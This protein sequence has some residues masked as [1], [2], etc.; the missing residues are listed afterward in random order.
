ML[1]AFIL[2]EQNMKKNN[3]TSN[4]ISK[5]ATGILVSTALLSISS[6]SASTSEY[7]LMGKAQNGSKIMKVDARSPL[8]F[9]KRY[10][11]LSVKQQALFN[12]QFE[13]LASNDRPPF[14]TKGLSSIYQPI[15]NHNK[16]LSNHGVL[17]MA[18]A[19]DE[20]GNVDRVTVIDTP[21]EELQRKASK[22]LR[23]IKFEPASCAGDPCAMNFP[24]RLVLQ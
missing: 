8:P 21:S 23:N 13:G 17:N 7:R 16:N 4:T 1:M 9:N 20:N 5:T 15:L 12:A 11:E 22:V 19:V 2:S 10:Q 6:A 14:P 18:I 3:R 24:V